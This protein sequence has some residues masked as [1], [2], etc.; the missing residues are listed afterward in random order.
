M[1]RHAHGG[2]L[3]LQKKA[4]AVQVHHVQVPGGQ[5]APRRRSR[6]ACWAAAHHHA[7]ARSSARQGWTSIDRGRTR[8]SSSSPRGPRRASRRARRGAPCRPQ[9]RQLHE[10]RGGGGSQPDRHTAKNCRRLKKRGR[11]V[12]LAAWRVESKGSS[13]RPW[14]VSCARP[15]SVQEQVEFTIGPDADSMPTVRFNVGLF[16]GRPRW[17]RRGVPAHLADGKRLA[18]AA[19]AFLRRRRERRPAGGTS[20]GTGF[21]RLLVVREG[22]GAETSAWAAWKRA[23]SPPA[24]RRDA[25]DAGRRRRKRRRR[26]QNAEWDQPKQ[27]QF[28]TQG[29]TTVSPDVRSGLPY[30]RGPRGGDGARAGGPA[31]H[32]PRRR[33]TRARLAAALAAAAAQTPGAFPRRS[34]ARTHECANAAPADAVLCDLTTGARVTASECTIH[35]ELCGL[36]FTL[37]ASAFFQ[38]NTC[39]AEALYRLAGEWASPTGKSLLLDVCCGTGTIGLTLAARARK[40]VGV[41]IVEAAIEDAEKNAALNGVT[42][43]EWVA[44]RAEL[45]LPEILNKYA[46]EIKPAPPIAMPQVAPAA[47]DAE[48]SGG[49]EDEVSAE[50]TRRRRLRRRRRRRR[51]T[52]TTARPSL[53]RRPPR[54][55][56]RL[57]L[58]ST[59]TSTTTSRRWLTPARG[60]AQEC[61]ARAS[62]RTRL[63]RLVYV[64][65]SPESMASNRG[66]VH[67]AGPAGDQGARR[68][69]RSERW[70]WICSRTRR[71]AKPCC[72]WRGRAD[73]DGATR[74][75]RRVRLNFSSS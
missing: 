32:D 50:P 60:S 15:C 58:A 52:A 72:C 1:A 35:E 69:G 34:L 64:S 67:A 75:V 39:A 71:T 65:C 56:N 25:R 49:E 74:R 6:G 20:A 46:P 70:P 19:Q 22:D 38:V 14:R 16:E 53:P 10:A 47:A 18:A 17:R 37:S 42:N 48:E 12:A 63:R 44:G 11:S 33:A 68:S 5:A 2:A 36:R 3:E 45:K 57:F 9:Y 13:R 41:D 62:R 23:E 61:P 73:R 59:R 43:C 40:V 27:T 8:E 21:W 7:R 66:P 30:P 31:R 55:R 28:G 26:R 51:R 54:T 24:R 29:E 4:V